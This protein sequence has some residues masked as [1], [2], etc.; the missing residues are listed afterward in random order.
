[1]IHQFQGKRTYVRG[2]LELVVFVGQ[3]LVFLDQ[4]FDRWRALGRGGPFFKL[5]F[6]QPDFEI[7]VEADVFGI[8]HPV[9][10][11]LAASSHPV[12]VFRDQF[13]ELVQDQGGRGLA[14]GRRCRVWKCVRDGC[15]GWAPPRGVG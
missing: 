8:R 1:M 5:A 7:V 4:G 2:A 15:H 10:D 6:D 13:A 9:L 12:R 3:G 14:H 11:A